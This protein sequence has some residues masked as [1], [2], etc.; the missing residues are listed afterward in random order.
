MKMDDF[1]KAHAVENKKKLRCGI[2]CNGDVLQDWQYK[3]IM[4]LSHVGVSIELLIKDDEGALL[5]ARSRFFSKLKNMFS[6]YFLW[7]IYRRYITPRSLDPVDMSA[8]FLNIPSVHCDVEYRGKYSQYFKKNDIEL[9]R[10]YNLDFII[11]FAFGITRGEILSVARYGI[12]SFHHDDETKY[13]G[14]PPCFWEIYRDD[15]YT[16]SIL[17]RITDVLDGGIVLKKGIFSTIKYSYERNLDQALYESANW[18]RQVCQDIQNGVAHYLNDPPTNSGAP[19]YKNPYNFYMLL[20][21]FKLLRNRVR[22][23]WKTWFYVEIW[24]IALIST[25]ISKFLEDT[26]FAGK[27][28]LLTNF[29]RDEFA[30]DPFGLVTKNKRFILYEYLNYR[31]A[32]PLK[33]RICE[34]QAESTINNFPELELPCHASYP[35]VFETNG[36]IYCVPETYELNQIR[37]YELDIEKNKW[38]WKSTLVDDFDGVDS[39]IFYFSDYWWLMCSSAKSGADKSLWIWY[40]KEGPVGPWQPHQNNP[41]K[42][43]VRSSRPGGTPFI[44]EGKL[45]RPTQDCTGGSQKRV[46]INRVDKLSSVEFQEVPVRVLDPFGTPLFKDGIH[47][48]S[49]FGDE[50]LID[51]KVYNFSLNKFV[52][53]CK[54]R[55]NRSRRYSTVLRA[56]AILKDKRSVDDV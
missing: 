7:K 10:S 34:L 54:S 48:L 18:P 38:H 25:P 11:K 16:G 19:I 24:N 46:V 15:D 39:T 29:K 12:W 53:N 30:A 44:F 17:Q 35:Y 47:T 51:G 3:A 49:S 13:R 50:T 6:K 26:Q 41:V 4:D 14:G 32:S 1:P 45:Y 21:C 27:I 28:K 9:I 2:M 8:F 43:D 23:F 52:G 55:L 37:L 56:L 31:G 36:V 5:T 33:G 42:T 22:Y 20:F 40:S